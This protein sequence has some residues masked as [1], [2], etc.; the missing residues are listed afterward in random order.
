M[1]TEKEATARALPEVSEDVECGWSYS[2]E[3][4][5]TRESC[6]MGVSAVRC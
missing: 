6:A 4:R 5:K 3:W 2:E 1:E